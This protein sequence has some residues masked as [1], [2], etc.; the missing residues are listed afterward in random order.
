MKLVCLSVVCGSVC[1]YVFQST[2]AG[3]L[4]R[5]EGFDAAMSTELEEEK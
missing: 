1:L 5:V 3:G 2:D 4:F